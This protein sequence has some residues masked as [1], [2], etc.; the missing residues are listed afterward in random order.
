MELEQLRLKLTP[1]CKKYSFK[2]L[3]LFGS[4]ANKTHNEKSDFDL[5]YIIEEEL[6]QKQKIELF[7]ELEEIFIEHSFDII[8]IAKCNNLVLVD[9]ILQKGIAL[10]EFKEGFVALKKWDGWC[11]LQDTKQF[12][13]KKRQLMQKKLRKR[14]EGANV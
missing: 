8:D 7:E 11:M 10:Y 12:R 13:V 1:L 3:I 5:A 6:S 2:A 14:I 9:E 4:R